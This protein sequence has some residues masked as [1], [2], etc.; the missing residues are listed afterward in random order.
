MIEAQQF[1][2]IDVIQPCYSLLWRFIDEDILPYCIDNN[3]SII[4]YSPLGQGIL[5]GK[6]NQN[7]EF[8]AED[9]R[10]TTPLF[11]PENFDNA[12][13]VTE[14]V[15]E[16]GKKYHKTSAQTAIKW[17]MQAKGM[18][19]PIVGARNKEQVADN[20]GA[21]GWDLAEPDFKKLDEISKG[22]SNNLPRYRTLF[23]KTIEESR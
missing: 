22:F 18:T 23:D 19:A 1:G 10:T 11:L 9:K 21:F 12:L 16:I 17:V 13:E 7:Y 6:M 2:K 5:T 20:L 15:I 4:P 3:I 14:K 8:K